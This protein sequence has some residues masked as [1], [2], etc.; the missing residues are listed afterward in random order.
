MLIISKL[1]RSLWFCCHPQGEVHFNKMAERYD[2]TTCGNTSYSN[3]T[4]NFFLYLF[5]YLFYL[6]HF[7]YIT[8]FA[9]TWSFYHPWP[10]LA[11]PVRAMQILFS[12]F[13]NI[14]TSNLWNT[15]YIHNMAQ[16]LPSC[17]LKVLCCEPERD[18][19]WWGQLPCRSW[20]FPRKHLQP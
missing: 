6:P 13:E 11:N 8:T 14:Y 2:F 16:T 4:P 20:K 7:K 18:L 5:I 10:E 12:S 3:H 17:P 19:R 1:F 9:I 15:L